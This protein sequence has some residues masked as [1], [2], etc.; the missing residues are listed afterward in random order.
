MKNLRSGKEPLNE[1][2]WIEASKK[3]PEAFQFLFNKYYDA[4]YNFAYRRTLDRSLAQDIAAATFLKALENIGHYVCRGIPFSAWLYRIAVNETNLNHRKRKRLIP[5]TP[6]RA[7]HLAHENRTD[8]LLLRQEENEEQIK[9]FRKI[10]QAIA[11]LKPIYQDAITLRYF[12]D[13]S[14][15]EIAVILDLSEN[16]VKTHIHRG[17]QHL[18]KLL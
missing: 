1:E 11:S 16:T 17:L 2:E 13:K 3:D 8:A 14:I 18:R 12:E 10:H 6:E 7:L 15:R 5:L 9:R 4:I